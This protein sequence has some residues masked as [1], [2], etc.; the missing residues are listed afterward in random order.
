MELDFQVG[1]RE[2]HTVYFSWDQMSG[3]LK[4]TVDDADVVSTVR[5]FSAKLVKSYEFTVGDTETH[6]VRV[7]KRRK[8]LLAGFRPQSVQALVDGRVVASA[9]TDGAR[10]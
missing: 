4:I 6:V 8:L 10:G 2:Q 1:E 9:S 3:S 7:N 5:M